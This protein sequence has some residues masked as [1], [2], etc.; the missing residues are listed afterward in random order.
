MSLQNS[1]KLYAHAIKHNYAIGAFN[2]VNLETLDAILKAAS[3]EKSP[4]IVQC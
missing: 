1:T 3:D 4:V 2:F